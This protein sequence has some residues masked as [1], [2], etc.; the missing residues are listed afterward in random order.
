MAKNFLDDIGLSHLIEKIKTALGG[1]VD[2]EDG[3]ELSSNDF[4]DDYKDKLDTIA[5]NADVNVLESIQLNGVTLP[6]DENK[7]SNI[8]LGITDV[9]GLNTALNSKVNTNGIVLGINKDAEGYYLEVQ[10]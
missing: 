7:S 6:I 10:S 9:T 4:T 8:E 3:K 2:T 1:K 5:D